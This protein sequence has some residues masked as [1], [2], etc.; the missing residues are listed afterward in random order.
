MPLDQVVIPDMISITVMF[1]GEV[2]PAFEVGRSL[3]VSHIRKEISILLPREAIP[4]EY[5]LVI[6][7]PGHVDNKVS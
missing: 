5:D 6:E 1:S 3:P 4:E 2:L 7:R